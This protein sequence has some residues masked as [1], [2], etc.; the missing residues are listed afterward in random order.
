MI[1]KSLFF[2]FW[3]AA[4]I[5]LV[6]ISF[7]FT[8]TSRAIVAQVEPLKNAISY[9]KAVRVLDIYVIP[10]QMVQPGDPL[11]RVER[12]DLLMDVDRKNNQ[13]RRVQ[14]DRK[15]AETDYR[16]K[17]KLMAMER[18]VKL[19]KLMAEKQQLQLIVQNN[20][21]IARQFDALT[22]HADTTR[23]GGSSYYEI[24]LQALEEEED[25]INKQYV[26]RQKLDYE[27]YQEQ[28]RA[29]KLQEDGLN[30]ELQALLH[31]EEQLIK[32]ADFA[33]TIGS[34]NAQEGELLSPYS[35]ILSLY[36]LNPVVIKAFMNEGYKYEP[37]V[38]QKVMVEST[39]RAYQIEGTIIEVGSRITEYPNRL[40]SNQSS[41]MWGQE[42]FIKIPEE[43][44]FLNG[45]RVFVILKR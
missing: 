40:K 41:A 14:I 12:P 43:N 27:I 1:R 4:I 16:E 28:L 10:G 38:G 36:N 20:Q 30:L 21:K 13:L 9:H 19:Q 17:K 5:L 23:N 18:D 45:E 22:G 2:I 29:L 8:D 26:Q 15:I 25:F 31:E 35:T 39:N 34:V 37:E 3:I 11:V 44:R 6:A 24:N 7:L 33:G 32:K 42:L